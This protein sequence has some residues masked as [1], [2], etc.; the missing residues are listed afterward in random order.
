MFQLFLALFIFIVFFNMFLL[1][2]VVRCALFL[3]GFICFIV[4]V[5]L[6]CVVGVG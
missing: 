1:F 6:E 3:A 5:G 2:V 4:F